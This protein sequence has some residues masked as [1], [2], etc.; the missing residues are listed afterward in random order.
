MVRRSAPRCHTARVHHDRQ[1]ARRGR[2]STAPQWALVSAVVLAATVAQLLV[3]ALSDLPQFTGKGFGARLAAYPVLMLLLPAAAAVHRRRTGSSGR[4]PWAATALVM[5]PFL[6]DVT[7]NTLDLYDAVP[8]WDDANH[9]VNWAL[10][11][12]G[13]G[14]LL[15]SAARPAWALLLLVAGTGALLAVVWELGEWITFI[16][17]GTELETAY[18]DTLGDLALGCLGGAVAG[19]LLARRATP[20][21]T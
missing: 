14:L 7:G 19:A 5:A 3:G 1:A 18:T 17:F 2:R 6:I 11:C 10:L 15:R 12:G 13:I 4:L 8:W 20:R 16:R 9:L 21:A